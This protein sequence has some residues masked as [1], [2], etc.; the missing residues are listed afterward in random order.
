MQ[1]IKFHFDPCCVGLGFFIPN[2]KKKKKGVLLWTPNIFAGTLSTLGEMI[3][4][5]FTHLIYKGTMTHSY[6]SLP[7]SIALMLRLLPLVVPLLLLSSSFFFATSHARWCLFL[8]H[9]VVSSLAHRFY[10]VFFAFASSSSLLLGVGCCFF[11][12]GSS[13]SI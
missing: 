10:F 2:L 9:I 11:L 1:W 4:L 5:S 8:T 7:F 12:L 3:K 6:E 13:S